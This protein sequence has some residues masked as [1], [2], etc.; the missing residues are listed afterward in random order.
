MKK[1]QLLLVIVFCL[2]VFA[3]PVLFLLNQWIIL[4]SIYEGVNFEKREPAPL[5]DVRRTGFTAWPDAMEEYLRDHLPLRHAVILFNGRVNK[6][7]LGSTTSLK[8]QFGKDGWIFF[9]DHDD[10]TN[11]ADYQGVLPLDAGMAANTVSLLEQLAQQQAA[12]GCKTVLLI[13]PNKEAVYGEYLPDGI[14]QLDPVSR[15]DR[16]LAQAAQQASTLLVADPKPELLQLAQ[17]DKLLYYKTDSHWTE[18]G[19]Y[20]GMTAVLQALGEAYEPYDAADFY[21]DGSATGDLGGLGAL[22]L[23]AEPV[24]VRDH[25]PAVTVK[26]VSVPVGTRYESTAADERHVLVLGDSFRYYL[27]TLLPQRFAVVTF[28]ALSDMDAEYLQSCD[29]DIL[30]VEQVERNLGNFEIFLPRYLAE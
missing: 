12:R 25:Q 17:T 14:P 8:I 13:P 7:L 24:W 22:R 23:D 5:P 26:K 9:K 6:D 10:V 21:Q 27:E 2:L 15:S 18:R 16:L 29:P 20:V 3:M 1:R 4:D 28:A 11:I 30:I 19:A